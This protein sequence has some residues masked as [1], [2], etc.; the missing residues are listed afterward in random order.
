M[1][2]K[3]KIFCRVLNYIDH[4]LILISAVSGS[5]SISVLASLVD[6]TIGMTSSAT[7]LKIL[8]ITA[9]IK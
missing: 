2:K 3:Q 4:I 9:G 1:S 6:I 7:G 8:V 5:V